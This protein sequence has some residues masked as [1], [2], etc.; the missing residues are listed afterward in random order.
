M[1]ILALE[2]WYGGSHRTFLDGLS[3]HSRHEIDTITMSARFW[4]WRMHGG[5][6]TMARKAERMYHDK[7]KT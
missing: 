2:P 5:A 1:R 4:K 7:E 6:V 3:S